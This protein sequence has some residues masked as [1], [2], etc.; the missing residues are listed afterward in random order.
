MAKDSYNDTSTAQIPAKT[1]SIGGGT[2]SEKN[3]KAVGRPEIQQ[4]DGT[5]SPRVTV[6]TI[7]ADGGSTPKGAK[8]YPPG[9]TNYN[10]G[11]SK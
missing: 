8:S 2:A 10:D 6:K 3:P 1:G 5:S 9:V 7:Q 11:V 4:A